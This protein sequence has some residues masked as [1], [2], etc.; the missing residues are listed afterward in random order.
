MKRSRGVRIGPISLFT[1]VAVLALAVLAVLV[2]ST[3]RAMTTLSERQAEMNTEAY[4]AESIG[5]EMLSNLDAVLADAS[6]D[7]LDK[8]GAIKLVTNRL[9]EIALEGYGVKSQASVDG[10]ALTVSYLTTSGRKLDVV[11]G[12]N[13]DLSY[14]VRKWKTTAEM[15]VGSEGETLW[16]GSSN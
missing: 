1:L 14:S 15:G 16:S 13:D 11:I 5:Q 2:Y 3:A 8:Q 6:D 10:D 7:G 4:L 9:S 12:I